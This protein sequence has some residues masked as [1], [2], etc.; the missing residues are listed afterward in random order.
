MLAAAATRQQGAGVV[1]PLRARALPPA[2]HE[3]IPLLHAM[4][5]HHHYRI[6]PAGRLLSP[7]SCARATTTTSE[8]TSPRALS[9]ASA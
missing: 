3:Q 9:L 7:R 8:I 5:H 4:P 2:V 1:A 6:D